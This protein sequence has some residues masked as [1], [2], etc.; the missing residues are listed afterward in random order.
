MILFW[1]LVVIALETVAD[2]LAKRYA[3]GASPWN[4]AGCYAAYMVTVAVWLVLIKR[5]AELGRLTV[6]HSV[7]FAVIGC[8]IGLYYHEPLTRMRAVGFGVG[9]AAIILLLWD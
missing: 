8:I 1:L 3:L 9:I 5:G 7:A 6:L 4:G 2:I